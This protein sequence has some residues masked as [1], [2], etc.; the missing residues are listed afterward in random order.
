[1]AHPGAQPQRGP[2][3]RGFYEPDYGRGPA[4]SGRGARA[5]AH[6]PYAQYQGFQQNHS[7]FGQYGASNPPRRPA[8]QP[9]VNAAAASQRAAK[10]HGGVRFGESRFQVAQDWKDRLAR[11]KGNYAPR[12]DAATAKA[13]PPQAAPRPAPRAAPRPPPGRVLA[14]SPKAD[15]PLAGHPL[16]HRHR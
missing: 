4:T 14:A 11:A 12:V 2:P 6:D 5:A 7:D 10:T 13:A 16:S 3:Q 9:H 8:P 1:M 15:H